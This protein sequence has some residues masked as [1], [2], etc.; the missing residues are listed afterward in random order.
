MDSFNNIF[1][2][3]IIFGGAMIIFYAEQMKANDIIK[4]GIMIPPSVNVH[5]LKDR[6]GFKNYAFPRHFIQG[7]V[8]VVLGMVGIFLD[9]YGRSDLHIIVYGLVLIFYIIANIIIEKGKKK[10]Y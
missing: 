5:A 10:F 4:V 1:D 2:L 8:L 3:A 6:E 9:L 7:L